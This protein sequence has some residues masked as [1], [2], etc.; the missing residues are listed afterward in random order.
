ML[1]TIR[2][3]S[4]RIAHSPPEL[5]GVAISP[6]AGDDVT[7]CATTPLH[8]HLN[9]LHSHPLKNMLLQLLSVLGY[10]SG[11]S[12]DRN[13]PQMCDGIDVCPSTNVP[14]PCARRPCPFEVRRVCPGGMTEVAPPV[15]TDAY[16]IRTGNAEQSQ[17]P[18]QYTPGELIPLYVKV[19]KRTIPGKAEAGRVTRGYESA[20]YIGLL[21]YAVQTG[22]DA[23]TKV[24]SWEVPLEEPARFWTPPDSPG[25]DRKAVMHRYS[26][27]KHYLERFMFRA[28]AAG[29]GSITIR[30]LIKQGDT[31]M[32][33]FYWPTAPAS[34]TPTLSPSNGRSNGD[35]V[36]S[37]AAPPSPPRVWSYRGVP[38]E[39]CTSVCAAQ[40]LSCDAGQ[41]IATTT[42]D[43][44]DTAISPTFLCRPPYLTTCTDDTPRMSGLGDGLCWY[45]DDATCA[46]R[47]VSACDA[48]SPATLAE[49]LRLCPCVATSGRRR[50]LEGANA[51]SVSGGPHK[52]HT[53]VPLARRRRIRSI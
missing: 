49:G 42:A 12:I 37:E 17:D 6:S 7:A 2:H 22:D 36:L 26:E 13:P 41:L 14:L 23:E 31:N 48:V 19:L 45:R 38:G 9:P 46:A 30:C 3:F 34:T 50:M 33:A 20:K 32:G 4:C 47:A 15:R 27:P 35:L 11:G 24:G 25:C 16:S 18:T 1:G 44:L 5:L 10:S 21:L 8:F 43:V 28:P 39:T 52:T 51:T 53:D 29:T 40:G